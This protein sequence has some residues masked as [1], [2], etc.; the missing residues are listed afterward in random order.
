MGA[1]HPLSIGIGGIVSS[2][3]ALWFLWL[4]RPAPVS[5]VVFVVTAWGGLVFWNS[6][7][8]QARLY[9]LAGAVAPQALALNTSWT[10]LGVSIG[11]AVGGFTLAVNGV[12]AL[13]L[14]AAGCGLIALTLMKCARCLEKQA[15][16]NASN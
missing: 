1:G 5:V 15:Q 10:Y 11:A 14:V 4:G 12:G 3:V 13:P 2:M 8:I 16:D 9:V 6:P 7:A